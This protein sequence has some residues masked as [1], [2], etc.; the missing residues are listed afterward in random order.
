MAE[1]KLLNVQ[2]VSFVVGSSVQTISSWYRWKALHSDTERAKLLPDFVRVGNRKTRYW[3]PED[4]AKLLEFK[5]SI[6][7]GRCGIMGDVT[8][9]YVK[10]KEK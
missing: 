4:M 8:Q 3:H 2:E 7:Q 9:M 10:K 6:K 1:G 5:A